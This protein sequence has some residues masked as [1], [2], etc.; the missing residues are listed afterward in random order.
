MAITINQG[1]TFLITDE[2]GDVP[3]GEATGLFYEDTR[4]LSS[5]T[6]LI[7]QMRSILLGAGEVDYQSSEHFLTNPELASAPGST[8]GIRRRRR[9]TTRLRDE[10]RVH[11]YGDS[12]AHFVLELELDT[13][14]AGIF[15][16]KASVRVE[17]EAIRKRGTFTPSVEEGGRL[18]RLHFTREGLH[19]ELI[20][21]L[22][23]PVAIDPG[24]CRAEIELDPDESWELIIEFE[25]LVDTD[26]STGI[27]IGPPGTTPAPP[28]DELDTKSPTLQTNAYILR[29]AYERALHDFSA[30]RLRGMRIG[31]GKPVLAAGIPWYMALFGRDSLIASYQA[32]P[33]DPDLAAGTLRA[34]ANL[35]G[36]RIDRDRAEE[37]GKILHEHRFAK[38]TGLQRGILHY[39][40]YGSIDSTPLFLILL[41]A[42]HHL[43]GSLELARELLPNAE[44]A[45]EWIENYGDL[46]GDGY[47]EY[48]SSKN[49]L[50][51]QGWKDSWD[52]VRFR[53]GRIAE[54]PIALCE[55]QGYA[56]AARLG[57]AALLEA[58]G[59]EQDQIRTLREDAARL[60]E[61]FNAD[62]WLPDR[63][64]YA[65][66]LDGEKRTVDSLTSNPGHLLW[67]GIVDGE[68]A[69]AIAESLLS[70]E[71][72]SGWGVRT[73]A[74]SE[75]GYNPVSY[76][77]GTV[78]PHDNSLIIAGLVRYGLIRDATKI[79]DGLMNALTH[80]PDHR[81]PELLAGYSTEEAAAPVQYPT[82]CRPQ[83]W[84]SGSILL[85]FAMATGIGLDP[86]SPNPEPF[87]NQPFLPSRAEYLELDHLQIGGQR[88]SVRLERKDDGTIERTIR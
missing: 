60:K 34:L 8:L 15:D 68:R 31:E 18:I 49:G 76:H 80:S 10:L 72:F 46:D 21:H 30:L 1:T 17:E 9:I 64:T 88:V 41:A 71:L 45:L 69:R 37:P 20:V 14:F 39:P 43:T 44:R 79:A 53:D 65:E 33:Y 51:N 6:L 36:D 62:F 81:L 86:G 3:E 63:Q 83:A 57:F 82:A 67:T 61:E 48:E 12:V 50:A 84:A 11:N 32:L 4:F 77:N 23:Q 27:G 26:S 40:Y 28:R 52:S 38:I 58:L 13:D 70:P 73:M 24:S 47:L 85:T 22:S 78:W 25:A 59:K 2:L 54:G 19:R 75:G 7:D 74:T 29:R 42:H 66:A 56:Y 16:V 55:V 5:Y 87:P 35:Q